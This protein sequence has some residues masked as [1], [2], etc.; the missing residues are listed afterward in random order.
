M[1]DNESRQ[2]HDGAYYY[3]EDLVDDPTRRVR[4]C[5]DGR[6]GG[7][8]WLGCATCEAGVSSAL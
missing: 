6:P 2:Q 8:A 4:W 7:E 1:R 5:D 3:S